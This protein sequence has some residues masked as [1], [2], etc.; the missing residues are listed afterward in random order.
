[1]IFFRSAFSRV[2]PLVLVF[3]ATNIAADAASF[4]PTGGDAQQM[5]VADLNHDGKPDVITAGPGV[6]SVL[7][8][9]GDGTL[10]PH[11]DYPTSN[12]YFL[13]TA[14]FDND[15][16]LDAVTVSQLA[17]DPVDIF[18]GNADG[19]F[20]QARTLQN[21][22]GIDPW[23]LAAG[24]F[25]GDGNPDLAIGHF[26]PGKL[27]IIL[28]NGDGSFRFGSCAD[29]NV[30]EIVA[31]DINHD[32]NLDLLGSFFKHE[33]GPYGIAT[34][35]GAGNANFGPPLQFDKPALL[36]SLKVVDL[37]GDGK[38][39]L[40]AM[41]SSSVLTF[42]GRGDGTFRQPLTISSQ[43]S[44]GAFGFGSFDA[45]NVPDILIET[46]RNPGLFR[47]TFFTGKGD[48]TFGKGGSFSIPA[49]AA[50]LAGSDMDG[51][52]KIDLVGTL[53][54]AFQPSQ[55]FVFHGNG[56]GTFQ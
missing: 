11:V 13:A 54:S 23:G 51:D 56:D 34:L 24:D 43:D 5:V 7:L 49:Y 40:V 35:L 10:L 20:Q 41:G 52:G 50:T 32:G 28:G 12:G 53:P 18:L 29:E 6:L 19:T 38:L 16:N 22:C 46:F 4:Y 14:D 47:V 15:G 1:M 8:N 31:V 37:N 44:V 3:L 39:D 55:V 36:H 21:N 2:L 17:E 30:N 25:D 9:R 27:A 45:D 42:L 48:G 33:G 26:G